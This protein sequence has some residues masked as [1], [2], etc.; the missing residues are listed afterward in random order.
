[1]TQN[2]YVVLLENKPIFVKSTCYPNMLY[3]ETVN[4]HDI[5]NYERTYFVNLDITEK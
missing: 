1:V 4:N 3:Q 2:K 5:V